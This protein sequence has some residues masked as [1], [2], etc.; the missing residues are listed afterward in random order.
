LKIQDVTHLVAQK[1]KEIKQTLGDSVR[2]YDKRFKDLLSQILTIINHSL[3]VQWYVAGLLLQIR[4][5]LRLYEITYCEDALQKAQQIELDDDVLLTS[6]ITDILE[7]K[8]EYL[9]QTIKNLS[10]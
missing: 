5:P 10:I 2:E 9:Q 6:L 7:E 1:L 3:L 4:S 8:I